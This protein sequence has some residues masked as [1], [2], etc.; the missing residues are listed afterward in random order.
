MFQTPPLHINTQ[1]TSLNVASSTK[2]PRTKKT[3]GNNSENHCTV[4][5]PWNKDIKSQMKACNNSH[6][7]AR[8]LKLCMLAGLATMRHVFL[9]SEL[10]CSS[11]SRVWCV[12]F[13]THTVKS[14]QQT[15]WIRY[16][17]SAA[18]RKERKNREYV[19][20]CVSVKQS[21]GHVGRWEVGA[22]GPV[23]RSIPLS[24]DHHVYPTHHGNWG[25][26]FSLIQPA[27]TAP[28]LTSPA[29]R[30]FMFSSTFG[31]RDRW[32]VERGRGERDEA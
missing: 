24:S 21:A 25:T 23:H 31:R 19:G 30:M 26:S 2:L 10:S 9:S 12:C 27:C 15:T 22:K 7:Q 8:C 20:D 29:G 13:I 1:S 6:T 5:Y 28:R 17:I 16:L 18:D 4:W 14:K 11:E 32:C 3:T